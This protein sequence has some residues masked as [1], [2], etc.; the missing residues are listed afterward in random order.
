MIQ[1]LVNISYETK[2]MR[3]SATTFIL[4]LVTM[5][6]SFIAMISSYFAIEQTKYLLETFGPTKSKYVIILI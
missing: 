1:Y 2:A 6:S 5:L 3:C 4:V